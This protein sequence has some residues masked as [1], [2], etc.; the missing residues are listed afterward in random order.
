MKQ[1][2]TFRSI[3]KNLVVLLIMQLVITGITASSVSAQHSQKVKQITEAIHKGNATNLAS[4]FNS[5]LDLRIPDNEGTYSKKQAQMMMKVF[6]EKQPPQSFSLE[7]QGNSN[8][9]S[10]Y[11]IGLHKTKAGKK[12]RVYVLIK[13]RAGEALIQQLR[14]EEE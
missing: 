12:Y 9:G 5:T 13:N 10:T 2:I 14:F 3:S 7:H 11:L 8:D 6:F 1:K 4:H